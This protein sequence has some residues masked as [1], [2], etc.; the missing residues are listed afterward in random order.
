MRFDLRRR[1]LA[2]IFE[3]TACINRELVRQRVMIPRPGD[4]S[5]TLRYGTIKHFGHLCLGLRKNRSVLD[6]HARMKGPR[7]AIDK[8][9]AE[10]IHV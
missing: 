2:V 7:L 4:A 9:A 10:E 3:D 5:S 6:D 1:N 8:R